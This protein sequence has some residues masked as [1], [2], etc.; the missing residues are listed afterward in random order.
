MLNKA[1]AESQDQK[2]V[3]IPQPGCCVRLRSRVKLVQIPHEVIFIEEMVKLSAAELD[4]VDEIECVI[5]GGN[6]WNIW[7][8]W[9]TQAIP[10]KIVSRAIKK[11]GSGWESF[12]VDVFMRQTQD[13]AG[14]G[15][16]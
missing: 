16:I 2:E 8:L 3:D 7:I 15:P 5:E 6:G 1:F 11:Q 14:K 10:A 9:L 4:N 12:L 13:S